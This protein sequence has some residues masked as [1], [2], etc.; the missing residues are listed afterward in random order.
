MKIDVKNSVKYKKLKLD[1]SLSDYINEVL[2]IVFLFLLEMFLMAQFYLNISEGFRTL[3][4]IF[5][6]FVIIF[7]LLIRT[8][9][10]YLRLDT[11]EEVITGTNKERNKQ[12]TTGIAKKHD[13][14]LQ[15]ENDDYFIYRNPWTILSGGEKIVIIVSDNLIYF[16]SSSYPI[17]DAGRHRTTLTF[18]ANRRNLRIFKESLAEQKQ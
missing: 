3:G 7:I 1:S 18:G 8:I 10:E 13:W 6:F 14:Y 5:F 11:L 12:L 16:N 17:N 9:K 2:P 15:V 4:L